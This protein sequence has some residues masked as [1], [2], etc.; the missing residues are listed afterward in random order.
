MKILNNYRL[1]VWLHSISC[2]L[3]NGLDI[4]TVMFS[5]AKVTHYTQTVFLLFLTLSPQQSCILVD[6]IG[7]NSFLYILYKSSKPL[8]YI[9]YNTV[10]ITAQVRDNQPPTYTTFCSARAI[11]HSVLLYW[12]SNE[13]LTLRKV[14]SSL[15]L[16][17]YS[18]LILST[19]NLPY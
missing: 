4:N 6:T 13:Q 3:L 1:T 8:E 10:S 17:I 9:Q 19:R 7:Y 5:L 15:S 14:L 2:H 12:F 18:Q 16:L 11:L